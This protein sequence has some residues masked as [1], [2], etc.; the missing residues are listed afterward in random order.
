MRQRDQDKSGVSAHRVTEPGG[1]LGKSLPPWTPQ[2]APSIKDASGAGD[3]HLGGL[4]A[5]S[6][7]KQPGQ[8]PPTPAV[9]SSPESRCTTWGGKLPF[10]SWGA[11]VE[12]HSIVLEDTL[13]FLIRSTIM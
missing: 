11:Y 8:L 2:F 13:R 3:G 5:D 7:A 9:C 6:G 4:S 1:P 10:P 12:R